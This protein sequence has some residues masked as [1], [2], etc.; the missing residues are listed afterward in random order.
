MAMAGEVPLLTAETQWGTDDMNIWD[1]ENFKEA[2]ADYE[3]TEV[4]AYGL[5]A[6]VY[7]CLFV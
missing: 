5:P 6:I 1:A 7:E 2:T 3:T 4:F